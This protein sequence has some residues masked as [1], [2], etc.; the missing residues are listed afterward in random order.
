MNENTLSPPPPVARALRSPGWLSAAGRVSKVRRGGGGRRDSRPCPG[1]SLD[2]G[3]SSGA[4][5]GKENAGPLCESPSPLNQ[6]NA[7]DGG[8]G[9]WLGVSGA[10]NWEPT[11]GGA[12]EL[13]LRSQSFWVR[14]GCRGRGTAGGTQ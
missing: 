6:G 11:V 8:G 5:S 2:I 9:R 7:E 4:G 12:M 14:R 10:S 3:Q 13:Q 1:L